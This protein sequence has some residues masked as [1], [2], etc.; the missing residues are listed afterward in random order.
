MSIQ[1]LID[2]FEIEGK[3]KIKVCNDDYDYDVLAEGEFFNYD[4]SEINED[5]LGMEITYMYAVD[6]VL[7]IEVKGDEK[8]E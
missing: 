6:G 4:K 1:D 5:I 7:N 8:Y 2:Q 3:F